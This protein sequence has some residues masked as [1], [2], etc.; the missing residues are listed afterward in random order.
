MHSLSA[1]IVRIRL[2]SGERGRLAGRVEERTKVH[3]SHLTHAD[4]QLRHTLTLPSCKAV[5][6]LNA[7]ASR[8]HDGQR[9]EKRERDQHERVK[10]ERE[11]ESKSTAC[12]FDALPQ[13]IY[14]K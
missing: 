10:L 12:S 8:A 3:L 9:R 11:R 1:N 14:L 13:I 6:S 4:V 5:A 7:R 2:L